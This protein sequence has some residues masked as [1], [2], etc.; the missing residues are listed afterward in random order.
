MD[1]NNDLFGKM[2]KP[3]QQVRAPSRPADPLVQAA[4]R[5]TATRDGSEGY[6]AADIEVLEGL[7]PVRRRPGMYIGGTDD[8]AMHH[9]FAEVIDNSMDE[10]VAGHAT[11][12]DVELSADGFLT[13]T[14]NGRGIPVDPHPKFKKPA[15]EVIMTTL[16]SG[17]KFDSKVYETS[18]GLHGVGVSVVNALSD[19]LEV[20]VARGRQ[21]YRQRF[22]RG[23]PVSGLEHLGE[24][25][26]RRGT[27]TRFH[28]DEQIFGKGAAFEPARLYRMTRSKAYLFGGVEIRWTC[29]PSLIKD[30]DQTP[31]KAEFHFPGGLKDY[32]KATLG[33]EFQVTR[34]VFAG[35]SDKQGGHGSLEWA[36]TW[37][38]GDGFL[39]SYCNTIPT[40]EGGTHEA[41][42]RNVLTRGL[43]AYA[44]LIGNKRA[45]IITTDDVMISAAGM[46]SVFIRE[47]EFVGQTKDRL[48]TI[49]AMR[50]VENALRDPFDHW[51]ADNPQEASK[52][53]EWVIARADERVRRRQ[54]KEVSRKSAV[55]KLRLPGKLADCTQNAAAGAEIFIVEGD[56][57]GGSAKQA[58]DRASQAVLP[59]R[60][61]ILNVASAGNDKLAANQQ[62]SDLIQALGCGTRSKYRD[63]DLRYDRVIIMTDADVDGAH[64]ASLLITFFY[65]EMPNLI[66]GGHLYMAVPPL[67]SIRQGG[68]VGYARDDAH[69]D[70]LLRTEFTGRGKVEIGRF[71][72]LGEMMASQLKETTM[73]PRKRT[74]LRVDVIDAEQATKDAVDAL[75]GTKPEARFRFI[76]ERAEF[77]EADVLDI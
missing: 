25:H 46:L 22:S 3:A 55:R 6:S 28:P 9:L 20:E 65:Q 17:G 57:A 15:L 37:F 11:F 31:A 61:K 39:N 13:V 44:D 71:K 56:S 23:V 14:D 74:L 62:I 34:E 30:K 24:V 51:L 43:R 10:A 47:P 69:K 76:Q 7:E 60:G 29:D 4:K 36:V 59:L 73:D 27:K 52:L 48:A 1:D 8:K 35:K 12:I 32:L 50:I 38:G 40:P 2:E 45:S 16:H 77:A 64:I 19:H 18:G 70:E 49:E 42:F 67:Y 33:D 68:K 58:R 63:E 75:M 5:T 21:L 54:E 66:R 72:G 41:G 53:L 26:N